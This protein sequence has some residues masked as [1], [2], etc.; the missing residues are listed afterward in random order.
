MR[1]VS[2]SGGDTHFAEAVISMEAVDFAPPAPPLD[3]AKVGPARSLSVIAG[4]ANW[5][6]DAFHPAPARQFMLCLRGGGTLS[7]TDGESR[8]FGAGDVILLEDTDGGGHATRFTGDT[9]I[10]VVRLAD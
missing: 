5:R 10:A 4:D 9:L 3:F 2:D 6:G 1:V 8:D 7:V